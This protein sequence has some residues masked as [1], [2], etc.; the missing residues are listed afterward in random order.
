M[1]DVE[2]AP[3]WPRSLYLQGIGYL[4]YLADIQSRVCFVIMLLYYFC[5]SIVEEGYKLRLNSTIYYATL[6]SDAQI[7]TI[8]LNFTLYLNNTFYQTP[9]SVTLQLSGSNLF[10]SYFTFT[11]NRPLETVT[12]SDSD[13]ESATNPLKVSKSIV[14]VNRAQAGEYQAIISAT[15]NPQGDI[16]SATVAL[17]VTQGTNNSVLYSNAI[18]R[19]FFILAF[20][21]FGGGGGGIT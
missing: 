21:T 16:E 7:N 3:N 12:F 18:Q 15:V 11:N 6:S 4:N 19:M 14:Y 1:L 2:C 20:F 13:K 9:S 5:F 10:T 8:V 17:T